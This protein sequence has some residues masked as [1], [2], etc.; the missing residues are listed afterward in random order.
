MSSFM[1]ICFV[2]PWNSNHWLEWVVK[3]AKRGKKLQDIS[4]VKNVMER[5]W[6]LIGN[7]QTLNRNYDRLYQK[8]YFLT[9]EEITSF[10]AS[11][12]YNLRPPKSFRSYWL[13]DVILPISNERFSQT[14]TNF[15]NFYIFRP[16]IKWKITPSCPHSIQ[17]LSVSQNYTPLV[18]K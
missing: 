15:K 16:S 1:F 8:T 3:I 14:L 12:F 5:N 11:I 13:P 4:L 9:S 2:I 18:R 7:H 10:F 6:L 17:K